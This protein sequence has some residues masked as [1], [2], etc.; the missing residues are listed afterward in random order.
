MLNVGY[1]DCSPTIDSNGAIESN[2]DGEDEMWYCLLWGNHERHIS[3]NVTTV[4]YY[5]ANEAK[6]DST[7]TWTTDLS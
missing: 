3:H 1:D 6:D 5:F 4:K 7:Y 2:Q